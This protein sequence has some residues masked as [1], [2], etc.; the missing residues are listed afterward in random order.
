MYRVKCTVFRFV[1]FW[2]NFHNFLYSLSLLLSLSLF[3]FLSPISVC[4]EEC[5]RLTDTLHK[6]HTIM[7]FR[8]IFSFGCMWEKII[9]KLRRRYSKNVY[10]CMQLI[11]N[12]T[13]CQKRVFFVH[14][15][16][17][18]LYTINDVFIF[19]KNRK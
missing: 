14:A 15:R 6:T 12:R 7:W 3:L 9:G 4:M 18:T 19:M 11:S 13:V 17:Y 16:Y 8:G 5:V 2:K 10:L 1:L